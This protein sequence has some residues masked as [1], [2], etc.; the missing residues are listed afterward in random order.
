MKELRKKALQNKIR[1]AKEIEKDK[2]EQEELLSKASESLDDMIFD[3]NYDEKNINNRLDF[4]KIKTV[5]IL[6]AEHLHTQN[7]ISVEELE[8][9]RE[10]GDF[11]RIAQLFKEN[12]PISLIQQIINSLDEET[13]L[14]ALS[15]IEIPEYI[16]KNAPEGFSQANLGLYMKRLFS[17]QNKPNDTTTKND[18]INFD[19]IELLNEVQ[20]INI[21]KGNEE[22]LYKKII[23]STK[24]PQKTLSFTNMFID[25]N[26]APKVKT[27]LK[28]KGYTANGKWVYEP[29]VEINL[30][31]VFYI[32]KHRD[33]GIQ[34]IRGVNIE[35]L[36]IFYSEFGIED[37]NLKSIQKAKYI[38]TE[39]D[40]LYNDLFHEFQKLK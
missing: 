16:I 28:N 22:R 13:S 17:Q 27:I 6:I 2:S 37:Y 3:N 38:N 10:K 23:N 18:N 34:I 20:R 40:E 7:K 33:F 5:G 21:E 24:P 26:N 9:L 29:D 32:L 1:T 14:K 35:L 36:K 8:N 39:Y 30:A 31:K 15:N 4:A 11:F 12:N 19:R 25:P